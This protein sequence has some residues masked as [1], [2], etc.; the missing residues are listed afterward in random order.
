MSPSLSL[1]HLT[2][3]PSPRQRWSPRKPETFAS[4]SG[5]CQLKVWDCR[6]PQH[7]VQSFKAHDYEI[8]CCDWAKYD[9]NIIVTGS[10]DKSVRGFD[11]R[12]GPGAPPL[13]VL[14]GHS[15]AVRQVK[16][17]PHHPTIIASC[18]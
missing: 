14:E 2:H 17:S 13:F 3:N 12:A 15:Y 4:V 10:V 11:I 6:N 18:G 8:L 16:T 1:S 5:D 9:E 7:S